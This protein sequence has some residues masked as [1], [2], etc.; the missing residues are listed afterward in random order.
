[1]LKRDRVMC[2]SMSK[3]KRTMEKAYPDLNVFELYNLACTPPFELGGNCTGIIG[4]GDEGRYGITCVSRV[5]S[6]VWQDE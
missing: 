5:I 2:S 6:W 1:M 3:K 4:F